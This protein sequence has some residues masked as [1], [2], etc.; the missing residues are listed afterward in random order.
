MGA[1]GC[2][3]KRIEEKC[4]IDSKDSVK[5]Q[6]VTKDLTKDTETDEDNDEPYQ[7]L[8]NNTISGYYWDTNPN[9]KKVYLMVKSRNYQDYSK[10][11][12]L[13]QELLI[14]VYE[15]YKRYWEKLKKKPLCGGL[16]K[17]TESIKGDRKSVTRVI[18]A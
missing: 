6:F 13:V 7:E 9:P 4:N 2:N 3:M 18:N 17:K 1:M 11:V 14:N 8:K 10:A 5:L 16:I 15:D 12:M